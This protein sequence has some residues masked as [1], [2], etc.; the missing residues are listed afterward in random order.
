MWNEF[1]KAACGIGFVPDWNAVAGITAALGV[2]IA[3]ATPAVQAISTWRTKARDDSLRVRK[4]ASLAMPSILQL[5]GKLNILPENLKMAEQELSI[6]KRQADQ[7]LLPELA[8]LIGLVDL[9]ELLPEETASHLL[10]L[11][12]W[13][14]A[15]VALTK[16]KLEELTSMNLF[17]FKLTSDWILHHIERLQVHADHVRNWASDN[18]MLP[19]D[20]R[21]PSH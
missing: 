20:F 4:Q 17:E 16:P 1:A 13:G 12:S 11:Y 9:A 8:G 5:V 3:L 19:Q 6:D 2:F 10:N 21:D 14:N 15:Y 7:L 18:Q